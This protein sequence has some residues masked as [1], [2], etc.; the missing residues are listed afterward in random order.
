MRGEDNLVH[1]K[2]PNPQNKHSDQQGKVWPRFNGGQRLSTVQ[3][4][5]TEAGARQE[6]GRRHGVG[7]GVISNREVVRGGLN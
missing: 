3:G 4:V 1:R 5:H 6:R 7:A 2:L